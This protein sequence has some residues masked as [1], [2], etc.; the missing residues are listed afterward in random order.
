MKEQPRR[1]TE[2]DFY[3]EMSDVAYRNGSFRNGN[4][5]GYRMIAQF[6]DRVPLED[7]IYNDEN[8]WP[9][10]HSDDYYSFTANR[11][12]AIDGDILRRMIDLTLYYEQTLHNIP[13]PLHIAEASYGLKGREA[14]ETGG[15]SIM[16]HTLSINIDNDSKKLSLIQLVTYKDMYDR[17]VAQSSSGRLDHS[18]TDYDT[19]SIVPYPSA[20][21]DE[22]EE[23]AIRVVTIPMQFM[24]SAARQLEVADVMQSHDQASL[25][26]LDKMMQIAGQVESMKADTD[27]EIAFATLDSM[28]KVF[29]KQLHMNF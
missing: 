7:L 9:M 3:K 18:S 27:L 22:E 15:P 25:I 19:T 17:L 28:K 14:V 11:F 16:E 26:D 29:R 6:H 1:L 8:E 13:L 20:E 24:A 4:L 12:S 2:K 21:E 10:P 23:D 5:D